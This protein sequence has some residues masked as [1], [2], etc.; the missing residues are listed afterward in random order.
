[1]AC[2][3]LMVENTNGLSIVDGEKTDR[4]IQSAEQR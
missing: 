1:M 3:L 2:L 4:W